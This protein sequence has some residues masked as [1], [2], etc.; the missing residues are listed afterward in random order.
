[1]PLQ[2]EK[3]KKNKQRQW[4]QD[5]KHSNLKKKSTMLHDHEKV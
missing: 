5:Q 3:S 4:Q 1:M 2:S